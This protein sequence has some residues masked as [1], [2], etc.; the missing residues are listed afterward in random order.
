MARALVELKL[1]FPYLNSTLGFC[2]LS[3]STPP[4]LPPP[5]LYISR[6]DETASSQICFS[7]ALT[8]TRVGDGV[9][10]CSELT[11]RSGS[12][13]HLEVTLRKLWLQLQGH[14]TSHKRPTQEPLYYTS[15]NVLKNILFLI[16][17]TC[18][19]YVCCI[20]ECKCS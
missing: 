19:C 6:N 13:V 10:V 3:F 2:F 5:P 1:A 14:M 18:V 12:A 20:Q 15:L 4:L 9:C 8:G 16:M 17:C 11:A 7:K